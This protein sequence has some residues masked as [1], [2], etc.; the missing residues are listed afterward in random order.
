MEG[1]TTPL[2]LLGAVVHSIGLLLAL[3]AE[4]N[5]GCS[6]VAAAETADRFDHQD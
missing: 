5:A 4:D 6:L 1:D 2:S 3:V